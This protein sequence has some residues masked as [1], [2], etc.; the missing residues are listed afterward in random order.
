MWKTQ[1]CKKLSLTFNIFV[2]FVLIENYN[3]ILCIFIINLI[4]T[5]FSNVYF[6]IFLGVAGGNNLTLTLTVGNIIIQMPCLHPMK[7]DWFMEW[8]EM[9]DSSTNSHTMKLVLYSLIKYFVSWIICLF[10]QNSFLII[11]SICAL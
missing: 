9:C 8:M 11:V 1:Y 10:F 5:L 3:I 2:A 6:C 4:F 7:S